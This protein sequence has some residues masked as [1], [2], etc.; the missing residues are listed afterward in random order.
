MGNTMSRFQIIIDST[1]EAIKDINNSNKET[2]SKQEVVNILSELNKKN[3]TS[4]NKS[5]VEDKLEVLSNIAHHWRQPLN[6]LSIT[7]GI[8]KQYLQEDGSEYILDDILLNINKNLENIKELSSV[9][10]D[11]SR[12]VL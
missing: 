12:D 6:N 1:T 4:S 10:D 11:Y 2:Y 8:I 9:I 5:A 3:M 7:L